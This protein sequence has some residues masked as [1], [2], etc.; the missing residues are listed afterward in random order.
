MLFFL[1]LWYCYNFCL[2]FVLFF[3]FSFC[4]PL[5]SI[6]KLLIHTYSTFNVLHSVTFLSFT[7]FFA[8]DFFLHHFFSLCNSF[9]L[10]YI[11]SFAFV[12]CCC[13]CCTFWD[14][15]FHSV[16]IVFFCLYRLCC[17][18]GSPHVFTFFCSAP[19]KIVSHFLRNFVETPHLGLFGP[20]VC[21][22]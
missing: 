1:R 17:F 13:C 2:L 6:R 15:D 22:G 9:V 16:A 4:F 20:A 3:I 12:R 5:I 18:Q 11:L 19:T 8:V 21:V 10:P 14:M 7:I